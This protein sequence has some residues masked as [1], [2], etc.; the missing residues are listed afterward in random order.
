MDPFP[1][2]NQ[3]A[4]LGSLRSVLSYV[5]KMLREL[6]SEGERGE[7]T[8]P[9]IRAVLVSMVEVRESE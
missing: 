7:G 9:H 2:I 8:I 5:L 4:S 6:V 1:T 3:H